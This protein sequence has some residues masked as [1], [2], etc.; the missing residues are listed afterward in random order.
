VNGLWLAVAMWKNDNYQ[1]VVRSF[2]VKADTADE[3]VHLL[4]WH[5]HI[6][7]DTLVEC[8]EVILERDVKI[9][10]TQLF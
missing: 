1:I 3:A 5:N 7:K 6:S 8:T 4:K 10:D 2:L 9:L